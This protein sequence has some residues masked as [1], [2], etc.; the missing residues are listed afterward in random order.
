MGSSK[1]YVG[2]G[3][4]A[5]AGQTDPKSSNKTGRPSAN[6]ISASEMPMASKG[7]KG[8]KPMNRT[9]GHEEDQGT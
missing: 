6:S 9:R 4:V 2:A 8:I 3:K 7:A 5:G 1:S